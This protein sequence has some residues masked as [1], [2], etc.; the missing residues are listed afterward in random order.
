M[1]IASPSSSSD[2]LSSYLERA[3]ALAALPTRQQRQAA[4]QL[5]EEVEEEAYG[6]KLDIC[7]SLDAV[8]AA[9]YQATGYKYEYAQEH[10]RRD[11]AA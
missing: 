8:R 5:D 3:E 2:I 6:G 1:A 11:T 4:E 7:D 10:P 9:I